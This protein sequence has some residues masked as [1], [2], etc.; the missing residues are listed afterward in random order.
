MQPTICGKC[1]RVLKNPV[2]IE[3]GYGP[4]C[5]GATTSAQREHKKPFTQMTIFDPADESDYGYKLLHPTKDAG[6][7]LVIT[8]HDRGGKSA[9]NNMEAILAKISRE[10]GEIEGIPIIYCDSDG[11]W[12]GVRLGANGRVSFYPLVKGRRIN[13]VREALQ[14]ATGRATA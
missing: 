4:Q 13:D 14:A 2:S 1:H 9:T 5:Y 6:P 3:R 11:M 12:D 10:A 7:V 8:D